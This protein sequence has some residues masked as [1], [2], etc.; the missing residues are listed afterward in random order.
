MKKYGNQIKNNN[1]ND[2]E[3]LQSSIY[4]QRQVAKEVESFLE[5]EQP[6]QNNLKSFEKQL[7]RKLQGGEPTSAQKALDGSVSLPSIPNNRTINQPEEA[8]TV[9]H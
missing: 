5:R 6:T 3:S 2:A 1:S 9:A 7:Y 8:T 4:M